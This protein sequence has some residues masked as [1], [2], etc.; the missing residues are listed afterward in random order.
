MS[1]VTSLF[2]IF[3][4]ENKK[5]TT[6][7]NIYSILEERPKALLNMFLIAVDRLT[8]LRRRQEVIFESIF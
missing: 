8:L 6:V 3:I 4:Y 2:S 7:L 5:S 1:I